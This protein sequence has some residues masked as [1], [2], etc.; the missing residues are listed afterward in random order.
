LRETGITD[1]GAEALAASP[2]LSTVEGL[3]LSGNPI[4]LAGARALADSAYL[5]RLTSL[6]VGD[7]NLP[8]EARDL[9]RERFGHVF[10]K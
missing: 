4:G 7:A 6:Q 10:T 2:L 9:L 8:A 1:A 5:N 3:N